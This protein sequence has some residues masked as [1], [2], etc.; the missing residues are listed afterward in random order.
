MELRKSF[1]DLSE[2]P[3][4]KSFNENVASSSN[5]E[6]KKASEDKSTLDEL[7]ELEKLYNQKV[8]SK[9]SP[10]FKFAYVLYLNHLKLQQNLYLW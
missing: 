10:K 9:Y 5:Q 4:E 7:S 8:S 2:S 6:D 3:I 1:N